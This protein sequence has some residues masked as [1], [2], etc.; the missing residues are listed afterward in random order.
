[1]TTSAT[2]VTDKNSFSSI[3]NYYWITIVQTETVLNLHI[4]DKVITTF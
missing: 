3:T 4:K 2:Q 1:M